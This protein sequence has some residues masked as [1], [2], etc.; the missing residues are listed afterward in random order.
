MK[1][2]LLFFLIA[3][4]FGT[5]PSFAE[6]LS[7]RV[8]PVEVLFSPTSTYLIPGSTYS[9]KADTYKNPDVRG[10]F[11]KFG[12]IIKNN[13]NQIMRFH[14]L[15][16]SGT[17]SILQEN[18]TSYVEGSQETALIQPGDVRIFSP[19]LPLQNQNEVCLEPLAGFYFVNLKTPGEVNFT[20]N[21][22]FTV[23][24]PISPDEVPFVFTAHSKSIYLGQ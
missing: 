19:G 1:I 10:P 5:V 24:D 4:I 8:S 7:E 17:G 6:G 13:S 22:Y 3:L 12:F 16:V 2:R 20:W 9:C 18:F 14:Y 15:K 11:T 23:V 21:F